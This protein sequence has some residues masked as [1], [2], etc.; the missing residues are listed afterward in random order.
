ME[1]SKVSKS[2]IPYLHFGSGEPL[3]LIHGLG[4][5]KEGWE[6]QYELADQYEIIIPDLGGHG[7]L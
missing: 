4:E 2:G 7:C 3:V 5:V 6:N 1:K